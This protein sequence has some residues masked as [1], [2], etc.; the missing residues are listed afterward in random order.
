[1]ADHPGWYPPGQVC[2]PPELPAHFKSVPDLKPI[3]GVPSDDEVIRIHTVLHAANRVSGVPGMHDPNFFMRLADHLF[4]VQMARYRSGYSLITFPSDATY[5]PPTLPAHIS[6]NLELVSG[7]PSDDQIT[8]V[9]DAVQ[10]YQELKRIPSMFDA[11]IN[12][13]LSQ[14]LFDLQMARHMRT[15]GEIQSSPMPGNQATSGPEGRAQA[16]EYTPNTNQEPAAATNNV[17]T[18]AAA[19]IRLISQSLPSIDVRELMERSNQLAE[20]FNH[21][22]ERSN[23]LVERC[24]QSKD[25]PSSPALAERFNDFLERFTQLIEQSHQPKSRSDS[26]TERFNQLFERF[27]QLIEQSNHPVQKA[28]KLAGLS[29][30]LADK[31]NQLAENLNQYFER[32]N[33]LTEQANKPV[34]KLG[35]LLK[36]ISRVLVGIQHAIIRNHKGNTIN[37]IDCLVNDKGEMPVL[38]DPENWVKRHEVVVKDICKYTRDSYA[39]SGRWSVS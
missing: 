39:S 15:A 22:L 31:A 30:E 33:Q 26:L 10:T 7:A 28:N 29:N 36:N 14:H 11:R 18:G 16:T 24:S 38:M 6:V 4:S 34:E 21:L 3:V 9:Q 27:N 17:G 8:K 13:E 25:Q 12:M 37:A 32:S 23:E 20:R 2:Y 19:G 1:M 5:T 35:E